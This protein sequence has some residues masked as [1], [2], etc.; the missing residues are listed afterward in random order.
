MRC[1]LHIHGGVVFAG[2]HSVTFASVLPYR[3]GPPGPVRRRN[4]PMTTPDK[5]FA[6]EIDHQARVIT[7]QGIPYAFDL[8]D[9]LAF[10]KV[11]TRFEIIE[12]TDKT[13]SLMRIE[14]GADP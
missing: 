8:F 14:F 6:V 12:R 5:P 9:G 1:D 13:V 11:G 3:Y 7:I 4:P 2:G 10:A